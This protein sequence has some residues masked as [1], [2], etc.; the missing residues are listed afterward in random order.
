M[1]VDRMKDMGMFPSQL[2]PL[3]IF[4]PDLNA[5]VESG[6]A[7]DPTNPAETKRL[8]LLKELLDTE[9]K[10]VADLDLLLEYEAILKT[11]RIFTSE[12]LGTVFPNLPEL[13]EYQHRFLS[14]L[15]ASIAAPYE[16]VGLV[17]TRLEL[18]LAAVYTPMCVNLERGNKV[19]LAKASQLAAISLIEPR[20]ELASYLIKPV[21]RICRYPLLLQ[22]LLKATNRGAYPYYGE[23]VLGVEASKRIAETVNQKRREAENTPALQDLQKRVVDWKVRLKSRL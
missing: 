16:R 10:Y 18:E 12:E 22:Q 15:E 13:V 20:Y 4:I 7:P 19:V 17:F 11:S 1:V 3:P 9:R 2:R 8:R 14:K 6:T 5:S 21:Q 23:L